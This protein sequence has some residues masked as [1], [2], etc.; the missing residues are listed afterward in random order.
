MHQSTTVRL[1]HGNSQTTT[2]FIYKSVTIRGKQ[3]SLVMI[4][5]HENIK[6]FFLQSHWCFS[7]SVFIT[8]LRDNPKSKFEA[9]PEREAT[10]HGPLP[11]RASGLVLDLYRSWMRAGA[12]PLTQDTG[13]WGPAWSLQTRAAVHPLGL[14]TLVCRCPEGPVR[15]LS[16]APRCR[17]PQLLWTFCSCPVVLTLLPAPWDT[18]F[19]PKPQSSKRWPG[20]GDTERS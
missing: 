11:L 20:D 7:V 14:P 10:A 19:P 5:R 8:S 18:L 6:L 12:V 3:Y 1:D 4:H 15:E 16:S 13:F 9:L 17:I 2:G